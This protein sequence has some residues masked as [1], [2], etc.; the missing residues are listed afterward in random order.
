MYKLPHP[1][2]NQQQTKTWS[3]KSDK[4]PKQITTSG[5]RGTQ[6][7]SHYL[8]WKITGRRKCQWLVKHEE[9][10]SGQK[11]KVK[12]EYWWPIDSLWQ[13]DVTN[14]QRKE[15]ERVVPSRAALS[16]PPVINAQTL[17]S[18]CTLLFIFI[19]ISLTNSSIHSDLLI[20]RF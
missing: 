5:Q 14:H 2:T 15:E 1:N 20:I 19:P 3:R 18:N 7:I 11:Q 17:F 8:Q 12:N 9:A 10:S 13:R 4:R 6:T 16:R